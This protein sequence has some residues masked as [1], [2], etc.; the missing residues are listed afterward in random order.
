MH[1]LYCHNLIIYQDTLVHCTAN[2]PSNL[3]TKIFGDLF[4]F[5][6]TEFPEHADSARTYPCFS[7]PE[8]ERLDWRRSFTRSHSEEGDHAISPLPSGPNTFPFALTRYSPTKNRPVELN[9]LNNMPKTFL[10]K[11]VDPRKLLWTSVAGALEL[12]RWSDRAVPLLLGG[13]EHRFPLSPIAPILTRRVMSPR[14]LISRKR[15]WRLC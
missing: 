8:G 4:Q 1:M 9:M 13:L 11:K 2:T 3:F 14:W 7:A 12:R 6:V 5:R 15:R 10:K